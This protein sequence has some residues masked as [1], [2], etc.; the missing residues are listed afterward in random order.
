MF[1][2]AGQFCLTGGRREPGVSA[3][4]GSSFWE[5]PWGWRVDAVRPHVEMGEAP[6]TTPWNPRIRTSQPR[7]M[8]PHLRLMDEETES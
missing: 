5:I 2:V 4:C 7:V 6:G 8:H 1:E 3:G